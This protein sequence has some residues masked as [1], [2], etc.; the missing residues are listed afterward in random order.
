MQR[1]RCD[2][3]RCRRSVVDRPPIPASCMYGAGCPEETRA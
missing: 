3:P 2:R 1:A